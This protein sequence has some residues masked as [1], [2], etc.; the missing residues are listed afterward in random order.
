MVKGLIIPAEASARIEERG[1]ERLEEYQAVVG[2]WIEP[3]D[4]PDLRSTIY[5]NEGGLIRQLPLNSRVTFLWW[6]H[7]PEARQR[8]ML[9]GE[10]VVVGWPDQNGDNTDVP[11]ELVQLL[12]A[13][14]RFVIEARPSS[15]DEWSRDERSYEYVDAT[16]W[17]MLLIERSEGRLE[18]RIVPAS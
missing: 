18:V 4:I 3:V 8:A 17:A 6:Y 11:E 9:V 15:D 1:F 12:R 14:A 7:V 13:D 16:V 10:A 5:V 2:G